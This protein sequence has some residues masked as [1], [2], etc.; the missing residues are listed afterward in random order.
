MRIISGM[1]FAGAVL[2]MTSFS[3]AQPQGGGKGDKGE[4]G[5]NKGGPG[6]TKG[7]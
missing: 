2:A 7:M 1:L 6:G 5:G 3:A 4:S